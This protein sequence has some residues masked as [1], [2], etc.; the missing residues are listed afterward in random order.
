LK[1]AVGSRA[2]VPM[3]D[4]LAR[5]VAER[6]NATV[7][8]EGST[9]HLTVFTDDGENSR[10]GDRRSQLITLD[11]TEDERHILVGSK[12]GDYDGGMDLEKMLRRISKAI[13]ARLY[14]SDEDTLALEAGV[15]MDGLDGA[16]LAKICREVEAD[17]GEVCAVE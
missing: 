11:E 1:V 9:Y 12:I 6:L 3:F 17:L 2:E 16:H 14:I 10:G 7:Q 13:Y 4:Q 8:Y 5:E 15:Q